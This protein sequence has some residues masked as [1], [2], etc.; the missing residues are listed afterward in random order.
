MHYS[1]ICVIVM[2]PFC[3]VGALYLQLLNI[4][5]YWKYDTIVTRT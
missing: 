3:I 2:E 5:N 1:D 4:G